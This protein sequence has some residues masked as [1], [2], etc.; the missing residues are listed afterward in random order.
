MTATIDKLKVILEDEYY[1]DFYLDL[2]P[3]LEEGI[4]T[5]NSACNWTDVAKNLHRSWVRAYFKNGEAAI[6]LVTYE[7]CNCLNNWMKTD[8]VTV[9]MNSI[10]HLL[11]FERNFQYVAAMNPACDYPIPAPDRPS[12]C[13]DLRFLEINQ[14][15]SVAEGEAQRATEHHGGN[16]A[17]AAALSGPIAEVVP[18]NEAQ[19]VN[20]NQT[21]N[22]CTSAIIKEPVEDSV[23]YDVNKSDSGQ[24]DSSSTNTN[25]SNYFLDD[26]LL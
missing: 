7:T 22:A 3:P 20:E 26:F 6:T 8:S 21:G 25:Y 4:L 15:N 16:A 17:A 12:P 13:N 19:R 23:S 1:F 18:H 2:V 24:D 10:Y 11:Q 14:S 9:P 5:I